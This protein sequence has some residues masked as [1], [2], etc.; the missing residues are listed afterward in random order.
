MATMTF[1]WW[2]CIFILLVSLVHNNFVHKNTDKRPCD[3]LYRGQYPHLIGQHLFMILD[4]D[5]SCVC[6][7]FNYTRTKISAFL[8]L[9][10]ILS[11]FFSHM[12]ATVLL[13]RD[14][15]FITLHYKIVQLTD[16]DFLFQDMF[17]RLLA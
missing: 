5:N 12:V 13:Y 2:S 1:L 6:L 9:R 10:I 4:R 11:H 17:T 16:L 15:N 3:R 14:H 7:M 8:V